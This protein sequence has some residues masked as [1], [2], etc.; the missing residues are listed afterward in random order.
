MRKFGLTEL[1]GT[2][3]KRQDLPP[4][5]HLHSYPTTHPP[6][7]P[8]LAYKKIAPTEKESK[9]DLAKGTLSGSGPAYHSYVHTVL[10]Q[11]APSSRACPTDLLRAWSS[12]VTAGSKPLFK[13]LNETAPLPGPHGG[14]ESTSNLEAEQKKALNFWFISLWS[15]QLSLNSNSSR[16]S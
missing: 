15:L 12:G 4:T 16:L 9:H 8:K 7:P 6:P 1:L 14:G 10:A 5:A 2:T 13:N 3:G 11:G